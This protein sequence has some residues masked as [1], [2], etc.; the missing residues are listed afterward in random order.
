MK[1]LAIVLLSLAMI[2]GCTSEAPQPAPKA[3][4]PD[5][6]TGRSAFQHMF[7]AARGWA[8]DIRPYQ[9]QSGVVGDQKGRDGKAVL[10]TAAFTSA[11]M[12]ASK[13]YT[14][15]GIDAPDTPSR[16]VNPGTQ[17]SFTPG[18]DFDVQ[19]LK[20]DSDKAF[21]VAQDHGGDKILKEKPDTPVTYQL[22]W[23][24]SGGNLVWHVI[25]GT[26]RNQ[27]A[28]VA[29]VDATTGAFLRKEK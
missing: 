6:Q 2:S 1:R 7:V 21:S 13:P 15:S 12:H 28:L 18:N 27:A 25:Y 9:L 8:P 3:Q 14:W 24:K 17:D 20:V 23:N 11:N 5:P 4:P 10:W 16:G 26:S 29:D 19:F 22:D